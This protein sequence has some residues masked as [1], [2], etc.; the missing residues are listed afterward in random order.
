MHR[1]GGTTWFDGYGSPISHVGKGRPRRRERP[2]THPSAC[3]D[4]PRHLMNSMSRYVGSGQ[5]LSGT[6]FSSLSTTARTAVISG[7]TW[8]RMW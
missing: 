1:P 5:A 3:V 6:I 7:I 2:F 4:L 8:S